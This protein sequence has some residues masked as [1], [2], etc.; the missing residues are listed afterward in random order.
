M[1]P[2]VLFKSSLSFKKEVILVCCVVFGLFMLPV[3]VLASV[4]DI[5]ALGL[6]SGN[7]LYNQPVMA[8]NKYD[9]G[10][11]TYWAALRRIETGQ[12][13]PNTWGDAHTWDDGARLD[14]YIVDH[15][16]VAGAVMQTDAGKLG[17]V[18]YVESV[19]VIDGSWTISEMNVAGWDI[20]DQRVMP[21][22]SAKYFYFIHERLLTL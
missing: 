2:L 3:L 5:S 12:P 21:A 9:Y 20:L 8:G 19:S 16:P 4:T 17:H 7:T 22:S 14:G 6:D 11:C 15:I 10:Y 13:I 18:A 1:N